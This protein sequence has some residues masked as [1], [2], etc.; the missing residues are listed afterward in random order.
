MYDIRDNKSYIVRKLADGNCWMTQN[1]ALE[2]FADTSLVTASRDDRSTFSY[3]PSSC[4]TNGDCARNGNTR[5]NG[6]T[7]WYTWYA[8]TAESG[9]NATVDT[10]APASICPV[11][12]KMPTTYNLSRNKSYTGLTDTYWS[13]INVANKSL[14][15]T[16]TLEA[17]PLNFTRDGYMLNGSLTTTV[18]IYRSSTYIN[19]SE[20]DFYYSASYTYPQ[21][22]RNG[23]TWGLSVRCIA[24]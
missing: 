19:N 6:D 15:T 3:V 24:L 20:Y 11:G 22:L 4:S 18:G 10:D 17:F 12:W 16:G 8:A 23:R 21:D 5:R 9:G 14:N 13:T 1:L 2:I 7:W